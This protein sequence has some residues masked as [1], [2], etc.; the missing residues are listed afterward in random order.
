MNNNLSE[1]ERAALAYW[2]QKIRPTLEDLPE[3]GLQY[4][5]DQYVADVQKNPDALT[6]LR[7]WWS[8]H[9]GGEVVR[10]WWRTTEAV[11]KPLAKVTATYTFQFDIEQYRNWF[12]R[13][14]VTETCSDSL[15]YE[16][17]RVADGVAL[18]EQER[19]AVDSLDALAGGDPESEHEAA[20]EILLSLVSPEVRAAVKR[21]EA[22]ADGWWW[23]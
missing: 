21:A 7:T 18:T 5:R 16:V 2:A 4:L 14:H 1:D 6:D 12:Y 9:E 10:A 13:E 3:D 17:L 8:T 11:E 15:G 19:K 20:D 23:A 22:R